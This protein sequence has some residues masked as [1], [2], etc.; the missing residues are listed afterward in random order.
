MARSIL[1]QLAR[2][3]IEE[4]F[5]AQITIDRAV[6]LQEHPLLNEP[7]P[8]TLNL[9][10]DKELKGSYSSQNDS[11]SLLSNIILCAKKAAFEDE[12]S[13]ILTTSEYLHCEV[14][15]L[16][17]TPDEEM[18]EIDPAIINTHKTE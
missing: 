1:L 9:Y 14:E 3:S 10:R 4:V 18:S 6:L 12:K 2:D 17:H 5:Q 8:T 11:A 7:I 13:E 16:L 15:L